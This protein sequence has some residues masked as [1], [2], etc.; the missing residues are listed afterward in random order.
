MAAS[1]TDKFKKQSN[2]F[3]TTTTTLI[4]GTTDTSVTLSSVSGLP[5]DTGIVLVIDR[6]DANGNKTESS[7]T[8]TP[9]MVTYSPCDIYSEGLNKMSGKSN[10]LDQKSSFTSFLINAL[11]GLLLSIDQVRILD[12]K[13]LTNV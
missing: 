5:T 4:V 10:N 13:S 9:D 3:S 8:L 6:V 12:P 2:N 7:L 1:A 11:L